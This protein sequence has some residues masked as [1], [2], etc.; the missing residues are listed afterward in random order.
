[1]K[2]VSESVWGDSSRGEAWV[3]TKVVALVGGGGG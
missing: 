2:G 1:M 3:R